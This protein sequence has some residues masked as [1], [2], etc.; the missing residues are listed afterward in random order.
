[1]FVF[2]HSAARASAP[3]L[4]C[5]GLTRRTADRFVMTGIIRRPLL[6]HT[7]AASVLGQSSG[8]GQEVHSFHRRYHKLQRDTGLGLSVVRYLPGR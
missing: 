5:H 8:S 2:P 4:G 6:G 3:S 1:M 7:A